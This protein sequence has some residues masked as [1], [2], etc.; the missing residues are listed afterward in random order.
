M[1]HPL[2]SDNEHVTLRSLL[3]YYR[4]QAKSPRELGTMFENLV[5][6][7]LTKAPLQK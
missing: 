1:S 6:V 2:Y 7:Y 3:K 4:Q 5:M